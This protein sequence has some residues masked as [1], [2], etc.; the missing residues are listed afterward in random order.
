MS[1]TF[2][3]VIVGGGSA[4]AVIASRL[5]EDPACRV[6]LIEAGGPPPDV[7]AIPVACG[8]MQL[9]P[10][11]DW[12]YTADPGEKAGLGLNGRRVPVP[13][14]KMLGGSS[15]INYM[16]Y[17]RGHPGDFDSWAK[18]GATGWSYA[19]VLPYFRKSE[20]LAPSSD[21]VIDRQ[22]HNESGRL[23][24]SL[25]SPVL[26]VAK[27]FVEATVAAGI[28]QGDYNGRDRSGTKGVVSLTQHSMRQG[29][30]SSTY[31]AF[32]EGEPERRPNLKIITGAQA[33]RVVFAYVS[34]RL[35]ATGV[36]YRTASG[37]IETA[38][39]EK[40]V[41]LSAG[42]IG[43]PHLMLLSGIGPRRELE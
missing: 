20:G 22:A 15:S 32:L 6:A 29:K 18:A 1:E 3:F 26:P 4:G 34:G 39:A 5:S 36:H 17:V 31:N 25:R 2:D 38:N 9:N 13:R 24:V 7:A 30:R 16:M 35:T 33:T 43:S 40:E 8:S 23:G 10:K 12:M 11:V 14:G 21:I 42:A 19:D 28:P 27:D 41:I 37:D